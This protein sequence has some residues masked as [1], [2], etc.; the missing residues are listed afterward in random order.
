MAIA[1]GDVLWLTRQHSFIHSLTAAGLKGSGRAPATSATN[2]CA[3]TPIGVT[4]ST[5]SA[6]VDET[7]KQVRAHI[8]RSPILAS[9]GGSTNSTCA[10]TACVCASKSGTSFKR[11]FV[12]II[13]TFSSVPSGPTFFLAHS[14]MPW[15]AN[16]PTNERTNE[17]TNECNGGAQDGIST[18]A[19]RQVE[20]RQS[21]VWVR[22]AKCIENGNIYAYIYYYR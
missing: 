17:R 9:L 21:G 15:E 18:H 13:K 4:H 2:I 8:T 10:T 16:P 7:G 22:R 11:I 6:Q 5:D 3:S 12:H 20:C 14:T 19:R 1:R